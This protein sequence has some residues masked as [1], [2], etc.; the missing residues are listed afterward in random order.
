MKKVCFLFWFL[1]SF[2][3]YSQLEVKIDSI[4]SNDSNKLKRKFSIAYHISNKTDKPLSFFLVPERMIPNAAS[5]MTLFVVYK[6]YQN[7]IFQDMDGPFFERYIREAEL[8]EDFPDH[9]SPEATEII[10][11]INE[12]Y[13]AEYHLILENYKNNGGTSTDESFIVRNYHLL[14][15][16]TTLQPGQTKAYT[17]KTSWNKIRTVNKGDLEYYLAENDHFDIEL[18]LDL[19]KSAFREEL[20]EKEFSEITKDPNFIQGIFTSNKMKI[21][22]G[23]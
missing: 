17:I 23:E 11:K 7:H 16:K 10:K 2:S 6:I 12:K 3:A 19:K 22:F 9:N 4:I 1:L 21:N 20:S 15:S 14:K 5:S 18:V 13:K 8:L